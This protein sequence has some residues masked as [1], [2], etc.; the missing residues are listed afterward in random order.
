VIPGLLCPSSPKHSST[1]AIGKHSYHFCG[2][3]S[4]NVN[5]SNPRGLFGYRSS[6]GF[7][8]ILDGTSNTIAMAE[9]RFPVKSNDVG[10]TARNGGNHTIPNDC[11][12][13]F[14]GT[15]GKYT[16]SHADWSGRRWPDGGAGFSAVNTCLPPNGPQ[17]AHN[18]HDAQNGFYTVSSFH[19]GGAL[20][21]LADGA[22]RFVTESIHAGNQG[23]A[24]PSSGESRYGVWGA[25]G[26]KDG[27]ETPDEY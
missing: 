17:C 2:G 19:P 27:G 11:A 21:V 14:N 25:L 24:S 4:H 10:R 18:N 13:E 15:T 8:D 12:A 23:L 5:T 6:V 26:S 22:V 7:Q 1:D 3:D 16:G 9:R 20:V